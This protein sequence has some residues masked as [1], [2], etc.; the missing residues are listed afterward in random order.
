MDY[1]ELISMVMKMFSK[2]DGQGQAAQTQP[3][4]QP[5]AQPLLFSPAPGWNTNLVQPQQQPAAQLSGSSTNFIKTILD[6]LNQSDKDKDKNKKPNQ[7]QS[8]EDQNGY[9]P[10]DLSNSII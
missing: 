4:Q 3:M 2:K 6:M 9:K 8:P 7:P 5:A 1:A 10:I